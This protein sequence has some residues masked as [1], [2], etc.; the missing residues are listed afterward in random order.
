MKTNQLSLP[1]QSPII[2]VDPLKGFTEGSFVQCYGEIDTQPIRD[3]VANLEIMTQ[4]WQ[5]QARLI[6]CKSQYTK[7]QF[8]IAGLEELCTTDAERESAIEE[9]RF[10]DIVSKNDNSLLSANIELAELLGKTEY[11]GITGLTTTS[12]VRKRPNNCCTRRRC[13]YT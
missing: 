1:K 12:C 13:C 10:T 2:V 11:L 8:S 6:L 3:V 7:D 4:A 9:S 5:E